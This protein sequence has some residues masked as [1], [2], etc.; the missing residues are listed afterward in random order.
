MQSA[1]GILMLVSLENTYTSQNKE[2]VYITM[3]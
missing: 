1:V 3:L 2:H